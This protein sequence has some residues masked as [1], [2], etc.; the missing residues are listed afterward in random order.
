MT[1]LP[2]PAAPGVAS[3]PV[4]A[5]EQPPAAPHRARWAIG[6]A[7]L[8]RP[9]YINTASAEALP[10]AR[11]ME[12]MRDNTF[13][14]L[15]AAS[16]AGI[17]WVDTARSYGEAEAFV[18]RWLSDSRADAG[19]VPPTVSSKWGYRYVGGW[20]LDADVHELKDHSLDRFR[21]QWT[22]TQTN[23]GDVVGLYQVHSLTTDSPLFDDDRLI[24]ALAEMPRSG[25]AVGFSTSGPAQ[26]DVVRRAMALAVDGVPLFSAVQSTWNVLEPSVGP[27]LTEAKAS[28]M[29]VLVKEALANGRLVT[30]S[31]PSV[32][33]PAAERAVG[34]DAIALAA[35]AAQPFADRVLLGPAD[36]GQLVS[37]LLAG[38]VQLT[39]VELAALGELAEP[40]DRYWR[41]RAALPWT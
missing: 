19:F 22:E 32:A 20:R 31:L 10:A 11:S 24:G 8:G 29:M 7:V 26:A 16:Q 14:V 37:N 38:D 6:T 27:A 1:E 30:E 34:P 3:H 12:A 2:T 36:P 35:A 21:A 33:G 41:H 25:V 40:A 15:D 28:G 17:D 5:S 39:D 23:L 13:A 4:L 9:A 18:G